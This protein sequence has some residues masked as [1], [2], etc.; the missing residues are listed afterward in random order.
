MTAYAIGHLEVR[1]PA[2]MEEYR[3]KVAA[4]IEKHGGRYLVA[5][6][7]M[8]TLEGTAALPS[9][10]VVLEFPS[11]AEAKAWYADADYAPMIT[12]RQ[13]GS[14]LDLVLVDGI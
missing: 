14:D 2:W 4:L 11:M 7:A 1:D 3:P 6:G 8:E 5:G 13:S 12:L 9:G 10:L